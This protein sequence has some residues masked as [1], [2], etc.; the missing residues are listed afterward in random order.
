[1]DYKEGLSGNKEVAELSDD[2][3]ILTTETIHSKFC[4]I[5]ERLGYI[6]TIMSENIY[7][8]KGFNLPAKPVN[9]EQ[10]QNSN[11]C[12]VSEMEK[13]YRSIESHCEE[14]EVYVRELQKF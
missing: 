14:I 4:S 5:N 2:R 11:S 9:E 12:F 1:M 13:L 8:L 3:V 7:R 6:K 10:K